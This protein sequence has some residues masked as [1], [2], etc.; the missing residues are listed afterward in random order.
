VR[1]VPKDQ[2]GIA[3]HELHERWTRPHLPI[4]RILGTFKELLPNKV[5]VV[6]HAMPIRCVEVLPWPKWTAWTYWP[7]MCALGAVEIGQCPDLVEA[8]PAQSIA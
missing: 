3:R 8:T 4:P 7:T 5:R 6:A 1:R 2:H